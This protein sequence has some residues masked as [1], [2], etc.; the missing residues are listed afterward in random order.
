M[1]QFSAGRAEGNAGRERLRRDGVFAN[2]RP[3]AGALRGCQYNRAVPRLC[4]RMNVAPG[5]VQARGRVRTPEASRRNLFTAFRAR[6]GNAVPRRSMDILFC[7]RQKR[8]HRSRPR[9]PCLLP[10]LRSYADQP[11]APINH[12]FA[13]SQQQAIDRCGPAGLSV[14]K[15]WIK[16]KNLL[17]R[18]RADS[19]RNRVR[20]VM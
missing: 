5:R 14:V 19:S 4:Q 1:S 9:G 2:I 15:R 11:T 3:E 13:R 17:R 6:A 8:T 12:M 7:P 10:C 18:L 20:Q 16:L